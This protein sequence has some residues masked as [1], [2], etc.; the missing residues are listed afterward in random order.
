MYL[1]SNNTQENK[2][3][4]NYFTKNPSRG[5]GNSEKVKIPILTNEDFLVEGDGFEPSKLQAT[6][7][8][9]APFGH[10]GTPP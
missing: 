9:S 7:L 2:D 3:T 1:L 5:K 10:S 4:S 8:Q 6:D